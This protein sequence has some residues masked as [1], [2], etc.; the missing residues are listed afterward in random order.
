VEATDRS[1]RNDPG[2]VHVDVLSGFWLDPEGFRQ[3]P[4]P[5]AEDLVAVSYLPEDL[6]TG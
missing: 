4:L 6:P 2:R 3:R 5:D 1:S